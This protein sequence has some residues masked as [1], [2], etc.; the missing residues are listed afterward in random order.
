MRK[1]HGIWK[2]KLELEFKKGG[3]ALV[4]WVVLFDSAGDNS[5]WKG[6]YGVEHDGGKALEDGEWGQMLDLVLALVVI[7]NVIREGAEYSIVYD[8][9]LFLFL[10]LMI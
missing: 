10:V 8:V 7:V 5:E 1:D 4:I 6:Y 3:E 2:I 9:L